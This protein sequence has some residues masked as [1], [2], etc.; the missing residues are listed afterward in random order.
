MNRRSPAGE[1]RPFTAFL[2]AGE[3][4]GDILGADLIV[5]LRDRLVGRLRVVGVGG[6]RMIGAGLEVALPMVAAGIHGF[7]AVLARLPSLVVAIRRT[8]AAVIAADPD[9]LVLIDSPGFNLRVAKIVRRANPSIT[10]VDY[11]SPTVWAYFPW[12][13]RLMTRHVDHVLAILPFEPAVHRDLG[14]PPCTY[15]GHPLRQHLDA[16]RPERGER[17]PLTATG[18][19]VLLVLPGSRPGEIARLMEPFGET[20]A[21][22]EERFG[23]VEPILPAVAW[24]ADDIRRRAAAWPVAPRIVDGEAAKLAAFRR[25]HA[26][27][28]AS[29]TVTLELALAGVPMVVAYR[30]EPLTRPFKFLMRAG[31]IVLPNLIVDANVVPEFID[32]DSSPERLAEALLPLLEASPERARQL[33]AFDRVADLLALAEGTPSSRAAEMVVE[34]VRWRRLDAALERKN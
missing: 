31:S 29:G 24:L 16:L 4:S 6:E 3:V 34:T 25:A 21:L 8:A 11:V 32:R 18:R 19:P 1:G 27:L 10:I 5:A 26:A 15:V 17:A 14:G 30:V 20:L 9:V 13:A 7:S 23:A 28:A 12:R 22:V 33:A 2:I